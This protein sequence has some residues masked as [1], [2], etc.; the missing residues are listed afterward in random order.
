M[1]TRS[2]LGS[3][4]QPPAGTNTTPDISPSRTQ[5]PSPDATANLG[6]VEG[7]LQD[8]L[9]AIQ[10]GDEDAAWNLMTPEAQATVGRDAF[11]DMMASAL[12]EGLGAF[13]DA[14]SFSHVAIASEGEVTQVV[15]VASGEITREASTEFA[16]M[17]IPMR[18]TGSET[19]VD[20]PF[21]GRGRYYDRVAVFASASAGPFSFRAG[22]KLTVEFEQPQGATN[23]YISVDDDERP[24]PTEFD[25][26]RGVATATLDRDL[27]AGRHIATVVVVHGSGRLYPE[28][29]V[30]EA[31]AP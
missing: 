5:S 13:A 12:P 16:A 21:V 24:L 9:R 15:A 2:D 6:R 8:W 22:D 10:N 18:V 19:L 7:V 14:S 27:E 25:D 3:R 28:A 1:L 29:I 11:E 30:F 17:A 31:A 4:P 20:D 26:A 23:A